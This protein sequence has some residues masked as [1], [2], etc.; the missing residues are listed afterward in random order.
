VSTAI[1]TGNPKTAARVAGFFYLITVVTSLLGFS[2]LRGTH[3]GQLSNLVAGASYLVVVALLFQLLSPVNSGL[4]LL[5]AF[6]GLVGIAHSANSLF[7]FGIY[8]GL[9]GY[10]IFQS[11]F[12]PKLIGVLM[13]LAGFGL[14]LNTVTG[15]LSPALAKGVAPYGFALDGIGEILLT[16]WLL[17]A[18]VNVAA[19]EAR[20]ANR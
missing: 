2:V 19:W 8:C 16:L 5:A 18:G 17:A 4:S 15:F 12:L 6:F 13:A 3:V 20:S 1:L 11:T 7:F 9:L 14:L 10:L